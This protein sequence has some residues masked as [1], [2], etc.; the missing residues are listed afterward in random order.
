[1]AT[2]PAQMDARKAQSRPP[3]P[4]PAVPAA[5]KAVVAVTAD[6]FAASA[7]SG[8]TRRGRPQS[9]DLDDFV[10]KKSSTRHYLVL[11]G[12]VFAGGL[13]LFL[14]FALGEDPKPAPVEQ[15]ATGPAV[16]TAE[17]PPP[18]PKVDTPTTPA[19][20]ATATAA[21]AA[22]VETQPPPATLPAP[23]S[24]R[25]AEP[26]AHAAAPPPQ[27]RQRVTPQPPQPPQPAAAAAAPAPPPSPK[28]APKPANGSI[29]RDNPF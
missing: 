28:S 20:A 23:Q 18:P 29:V 1:M 11:A 13:G 8:P 14:R 27:P 4:G 26:P 7:R 6:P 15:H 24:A 16:T 9:E 22:K 12:L 21:T 19:T 17:I 10:P 3:P 5:K 25:P 2:S